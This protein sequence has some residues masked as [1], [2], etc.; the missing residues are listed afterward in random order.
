MAPKKTSQPPKTTNKP[1]ESQFSKNS[2]APS[3]QRMLWS[4]QVEKEEEEARFHP[5]FISSPSGPILIISNKMLFLSYDPSDISN[6]V[7]ATQFPI[8]LGSQTFK[9]VTKANLSQKELA[10]SSTFSSKQIM[11]AA[12]PIFFSSKS[13]YWQKDLNQP[14]RV[15]EREFFNEDPK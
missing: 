12:N 3:S 6:L 9:P 4:Q 5:S 11:V 15:I 13:H 7:Q 2:Q 10:T 1:P 14:V 8:I